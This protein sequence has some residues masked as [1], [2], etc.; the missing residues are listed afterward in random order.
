MPT[1]PNGHRS[2]ADDW[3]EVCGH[4]MSGT[5]GTAPSSAGAPSSGYGYPGP[6]T[7]QAELCPQC[8]TPRE[9]QGPFCE[10]CRYN[11]LT[12]SPTSYP[13]FGQQPRPA[14]ASLGFEGSR[15]SQVNRPAEPIPTPSGDDDWNLAPP[16][17]SNG[18]QQSQQ[19][20]H[21]QQSPQSQQPYPG[22]G[23]SFPGEHLS[24]PGR[25]QSFP[26]EQ[27]Q[28]SG[29]PQPYGEQ[30]QS[31]PD[32]QQPYAE[33]PQGYQGAQA[34]QSGPQS[35]QGQQEQQPYGGAPAYPD[36][37]RPY[38]DQQGYPDHQSYPEQSS[39]PP[40][41]Q[42]GGGEPETSSR[43][44]SWSV[45]V[46]TDREYF[47]AMMQRSGPEG[48]E[49]NLP[50]YSPEL[51]VPLTGDQVTIGRRRHSTGEAPTIDLSRPP[52]D[53]GVSHQHAM[54]VQ[55]E[56]GGWAVMDQESTN[57]TTLNGAEDPI[58]PF[59]PVPLNEGDRVHVGAW[60]TLTVHRA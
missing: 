15:P 32:Q 34:Y 20:Q 9:A 44:G 46:A 42:A 39:Y 2:A 48:A 24:Y 51:Q 10:E 41:P 14:G 56:D 5:S 57:G 23:Q 52:E 40:G 8:H 27:G 1:C 54:L 22:S 3:C 58:Q 38:P 6:P 7:Q 13:T 4:R 45:T 29:R 12:Q 16:G 18:Y 37:H 47:T 55:Q 35:Y 31:Y 53:P 43:A 60:T 59:V 11:F 19:S 30:Q 50:A 28:Y 25:P 26:D 36:Q 17:G 49:L 21:G 33:G